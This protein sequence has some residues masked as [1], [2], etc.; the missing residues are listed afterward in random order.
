MASYKP[1]VKQANGTMV[2]LPLDAAT[3]NG[4]LTV[5]KSVPADA[6]FSDTTYGVVTTSTNGLMSTTMLTKLNGIAEG[7][8]KYTLPTA[9]SGTLGGIKTGY[10]T[11]GKNYKVQVDSSGNAYVNVPWTDNN[12]TYSAATSTAYGLV[13]IG[14]SESGKNYAVKLDT[15][16]K[17]YV[18]V[19][20]SD[21]NTTYSQAT[22]TTLGLVKIGFSSSG[23]N[24]AVQL[25]NDGQMYVNVP[26]TDTNTH[27]DLSSYAK[28]AAS[29]T[30]NAIARFDGTTG[31]IIQNS[32]ATVNDN[33]DIAGRY[34]Q[35][36]WLQ[37]TDAT[38]QTTATKIAVIHSDN[39][40]Y[41]ITPANLK[42][43]LGVP[44]SDANTT[45]TLTK[46]GSTITLT[47]S[48]G[49]KTS[50]TDSNTTY[51]NATTSTSG[52]MS[53][54]DKTKLDGI[55]SGANKVSFSYSGGTLTITT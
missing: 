30:D 13:K 21:T 42:T 32:S 12:T 29:S 11:S 28:G 22:S 17:M 8:N 14:Y 15:D 45:Y 40:I 46:S 33:G 39:Y 34:I 4:G 55:A 10:T 20:W 23:K 5:L 38:A 27:P 37:T 50:V 51:S 31:K 7:A 49:S 6:K 9:A 44:T 26:W 43:L 18:N 41:Y 19:P 35:G 53:A 2:D 52:L 24:Y 16:G 3:I 54:A 36:S 25:N 47:G 1:Q 48:D